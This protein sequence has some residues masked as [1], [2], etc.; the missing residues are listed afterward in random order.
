LLLQ[1]LS[2]MERSGIARRLAE[3][4]SPVTVFV[5]AIVISVAMLLNLLACLW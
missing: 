2:G 1:R 3:T 5:I 4:Y